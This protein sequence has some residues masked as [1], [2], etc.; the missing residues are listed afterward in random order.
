MA[1]SKHSINP[2]RVSTLLRISVF[3]LFVI[4]L[5]RLIDVQLLTEVVQQVRFDIVLAALLF[6]FVNIAIRAYRLEIILNKDGLRLTF[7]DA[8]LMTLIGLAL[9]ILVPATMGDLVKSYYGYKIYGIKE[10]MLSTSLVDKMFALCALF[11][12]GTVS[13][14]LLGYWLLGSVALFCAI[15]TFVPLAMPRYVPWG[16]VNRLL[17]LIKR[18]LDENKL[19][20]SFALPW[21][22]KVQ[23]MLISIGGWLFTCLFFYILCL[24]F[25]V[26]V[27]LGYIILIMPMLTIAR[28]FP[29]TVNALGP[30]EVAVAYFFGLLGIPST[31]AVL[32]SLTSNL[33]SSVIPGLLGFVLILTIG[34]RARPPQKPAPETKNLDFSPPHQESNSS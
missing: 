28:L 11:L 15:L 5:A 30:M 18:S 19:S 1:N 6:Y 16:L 23:V 29:F 22:L 8:Y 10:E 2:R 34:H 13:G 4:I 26:D 24:A 32:I 3:V 17:A 20:R 31:L 7:K 9:N 12:L 27:S 25:P 33:L 14:M 21:S